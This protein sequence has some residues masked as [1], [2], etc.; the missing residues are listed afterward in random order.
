MDEAQ[1]GIKIAR[2][3]IN[4]FRN[5]F[6]TSLMEESEEEPKSLFMKVKEDNEKVAL[7]FNIL[8]AK[9]KKMTQQSHS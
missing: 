5:A 9:I 6:D 8:K 3:N 1:T 7:K 2:R 4:S